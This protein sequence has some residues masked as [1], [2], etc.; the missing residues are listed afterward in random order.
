LF[1]PIITRMSG[2]VNE[3]I[4]WSNYIHIP[5]LLWYAPFP[6]DTLKVDEKRSLTF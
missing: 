1:P 3:P 4:K 5:V 6:L 2:S